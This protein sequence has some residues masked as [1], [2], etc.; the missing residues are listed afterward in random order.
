MGE[1]L[2]APAADE[3]NPYRVKRGG[4]GKGARDEVQLQP[5]PSPRPARRLLEMLLCNRAYS[6]AFLDLVTQL[7]SFDPFSY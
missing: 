7:L 5:P 1:R 6:H 3:H 2:F 4:G